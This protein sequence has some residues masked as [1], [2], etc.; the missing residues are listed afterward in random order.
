MKMQDIQNESSFI[1]TFV[2]RLED[3]YIQNWFSEINIIR[4]YILYKDFKLNFT[5]VLLGYYYCKKISSRACTNT[6]R[7]SSTGN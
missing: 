5:P 4:K 3:Q 7:S 1:S 2:Q 6:N